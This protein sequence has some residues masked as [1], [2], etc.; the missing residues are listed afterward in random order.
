MYGDVRFY[1]SSGS[2]PDEA[3]VAATGGPFVH[4]DIDIGDGECV[5]A[6]SQGIVKASI[7][8]EA[9]VAIWRAQAVLARQ[10]LTNAETWALAQ[11]GH[12]YGWLD[13]A[14][15]GVADIFRRVT[16]QTFAP[17]VGVK[18]AWDCSAFATKF[19]QIADY[20]AVGNLT[21]AQTSPVDLANALGVTYE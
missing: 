2:I 16:G 14:N 4:V 19:L 11:V 8:P 21:P 3:I 12:A 1:F 10:D 9:K 18:G 6:L 15:T 7:N 5:G 20:F 17:Y 13:L